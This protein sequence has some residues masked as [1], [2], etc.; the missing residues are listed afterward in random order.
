MNPITALIQGDRAIFEQVYRQYHKRVYFFVLKKT[1][2]AY[3]AEETTQLCFIKL[4]QYRSTLSPAQA[5]FT[6]VFRIARTTMIDLL[7]KQ[8]NR[9]LLQSNPPAIA[10]EYT[11]LEKLAGKEIQSALITAISEMPVMRRQVF[12]LSRIEGMSYRQ[13]A[14]CL[15]ISVKT[16]EGHISQALKELRKQLFILTLLALMLC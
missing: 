9:Q 16:V 3:L 6:Q 12:V 4:W 15:S 2:S 1:Q 13:I 5:L 14:Q 11:I 7:R 10:G 8:Y